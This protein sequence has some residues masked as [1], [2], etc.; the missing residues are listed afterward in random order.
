MVEDSLAAA[1]EEAAA[2]V[3]KILRLN[4]CYKK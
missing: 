2:E 4:Y 1:A 3:G